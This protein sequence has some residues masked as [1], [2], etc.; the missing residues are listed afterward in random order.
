MITP[1][2]SGALVLIKI[3]NDN[4][5]VFVR[6]ATLFLNPFT[7]SIQLKD[8]IDIQCNRHWIGLSI[9]MKWPDMPLVINGSPLLIDF[10]ENV[11][12]YFSGGLFSKISPVIKDKDRKVSFYLLDKG[13]CFRIYRNDQGNPSTD[14]QGNQSSNIYPWDALRGKE[15]YV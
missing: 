4:Y 11:R 2:D 15:E 3:Y 9:D 14:N 1:S 13:I 7:K 5:A 10:P 8:P 6:L 12:I